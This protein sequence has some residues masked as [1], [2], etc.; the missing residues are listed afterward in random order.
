MLNIQAQ[1]R[2]QIK[3]AAS[4]HV[5]DLLEPLSPLWNI[6]MEVVKEGENFPNFENNDLVTILIDQLE[7]ALLDKWSN[8]VPYNPSTYT[9]LCVLLS[10]VEWEVILGDLIPEWEYYIHRQRETI[11]QDKLFNFFIQAMSESEF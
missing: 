10:D 6:G 11:A 7:D 5:L 9:A 8:N 4:H 2:D 1:I 3:T